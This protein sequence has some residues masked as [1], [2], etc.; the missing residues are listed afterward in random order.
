MDTIEA[1]QGFWKEERL[2]IEAVEEVRELV[3]DQDRLP[4]FPL[5]VYNPAL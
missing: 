4:I 5:R 1:S 2:A 3:A